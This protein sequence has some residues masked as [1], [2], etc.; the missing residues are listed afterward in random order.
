MVECRKVEE[1]MKPM[2]YQRDDALRGN[3]EV[4][5]LT[6]RTQGDSSVQSPKSEVCRCWGTSFGELTA[7]WGKEKWTGHKDWR[8]E[9]TE[10]FQEG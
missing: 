10:L 2:V 9:R 8:V 5:Y 3:K 6:W 4:C 1:Y 7:T